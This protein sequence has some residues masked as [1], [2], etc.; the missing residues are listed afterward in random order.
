M[1]RPECGSCRSSSKHGKLLKCLHSLCV[2]CLEKYIS[3]KGSVGC[4]ECGT[5]TPPPHRGV[6]LLQYLPN[7]DVSS[8]G[9]GEEVDAASA[10]R[11]KLCDECGEDT[12]AVA[13]C[14]DCGDNF[15]AIHAEG[16]PVSRR[17]YKHR[18]VPLSEA[19]EHTGDRTSASQ[20]QCSFHPSFVQCSYCLSCEQLVCKQ[21]VSSGDH[22]AHNVQ[23][24]TD[25]SSSIRQSL[26]SKLTSTSHGSG[27]V[28]DESIKKSEAALSGLRDETEGLSSRIND[29]FGGLKKAIE[30]RQ[31]ELL[32]EVDR[33]QL[34]HLLPLEEQKRQILA[35][36]SYSKKVQHLAENCN[37]D[38]NFLKMSGWLEKAA[39]NAVSAS[40]RDVKGFATGT[41]LFSPCHVE[42]LTAAIARTGVVS[43]I[44]MLSSEKSSMTTA[45]SIE[46]GDDLTVI[47]EPRDGHGDSLAVTQA[48]LSGV[49]VDVTSADNTTDTIHTVLMLGSSPNEGTNMI[50]TY[51]TT[52]KKGSVQ[53]SAMIGD[54]HVAGSPATVTVV[55][56]LWFDPSQ[57]HADLALSNNNRTVTHAA[58]SGNGWRSVCGVRK[59]RSGK[60]EISLH[61]DR[62]TAGSV[63]H[64]FFLCNAQRPRKG[65]WQ[66]GKTTSFG[67]YSNNTGGGSW[68]GG[69]LGQ[70]WQAGD[71]VH[72]SLDCDNHTLVG[73][74]ERTGTTE[75]LTNVTGELYLYIS[76][77]SSGDQV[78]IL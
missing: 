68:T 49:H 51:K 48:H 76:L 45:A 35:G 33:L 41:L 11:K 73:R 67:W 52:G 53:V 70:P 64:M 71:V 1:S 18:V 29:V 72:M 77:Y 30:N 47:I 65:D 50:A 46:E 5:T 44:A 55:D 62:I 17:S 7:S 56:P 19:V 6:P 40:E 59:W 27:S 22:A 32:D 20:Y 31:Q 2:E 23:T 28:F 66:S 58:A 36:A 14:M 61:L 10:G 24:I 69:A 60:H 12:A 16:H 34:S 8:D 43:D 75:T 57:C 26:K 63:H 38:V 9:V 39:K 3:G 78:T 74:H 42:E 21:C 37:E 25:A 4:P 13:V 54:H 15:C